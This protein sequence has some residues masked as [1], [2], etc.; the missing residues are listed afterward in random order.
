MDPGHERVVPGRPPGRGAAHLRRGPG[1][2][3]G[4]ARRGAEREPPTGRAVR[5]A[6]GRPV[7][8]VAEPDPRHSGPCPADVVRRSC[9]GTATTGRAGRAPPDRVRGRTDGGGQ[10]PARRRVGAD[11]RAGC[12]RQVRRPDG[13]I[14]VRVD[15]PAHRRGSRA[16]VRV[17]GSPRSARPCPGPPGERTD[18]PAVGHRRRLERRRGGDRRHAVCRRSRSHRRHHRT[19]SARTV[20]RG[21][22]GADPAAHPGE[23]ERPDGDSRPAG[24]RTPCTRHSDRRGAP[25]RRRRRRHPDAH[26]AGRR[27]GR[28]HVDSAS[29]TCAGP[30]VGGCE[31]RR[32]PHPGLVLRVADQ[33]LGPAH[34]RGV[35]RWGSRCPCSP[36]SR[37]R[38]SWTTARCDDPCASSSAPPSC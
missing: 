11:V 20:R 37:S 6:S 21:G 9:G 5:P 7:G 31:A 15:R 24:H 4:R 12:R 13:D 2:P 16:P 17:R 30:G 10:D 8:P 19:G 26:R 25:R 3:P 33:P 34:G 18:L 28:P 35:P 22:A 23:G 32:G 36:M 29:R 1:I 27:T 14:G 38:T